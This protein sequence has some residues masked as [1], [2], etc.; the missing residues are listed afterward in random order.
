MKAG[1]PFWAR[2]RARMEYANGDTNA[3]GMMIT[4]RRPRTDPVRGSRFKIGGTDR[5][6]QEEPSNGHEDEGISAVEI[7]NFNHG[8]FIASYRKPEFVHHHRPAADLPQGCA[9]T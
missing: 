3:P 2:V 1:C 5:T 4:W 6:H 8:R 9:I 7:S